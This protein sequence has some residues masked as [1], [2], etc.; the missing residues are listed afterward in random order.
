MIQQDEYFK[1][2]LDEKF[3]HLEKKIDNHGH[4]MNMK[5]E[6]IDSRVDEL[7]EHKANQEGSWQAYGKTATVAGGVVGGLIAWLTNKFF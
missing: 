2:W 6:T 3:E 1:K 4:S 7:E 5:I